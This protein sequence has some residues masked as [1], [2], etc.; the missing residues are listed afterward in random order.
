MLKKKQRDAIQLLV[1]TEMKDSEIKEKLNIS[2]ATFWRWKKN[3][4]LCAELE[5]E[6]RRKFKSLQTKALHTMA[7]L[8][9]EL[10]NFMDFDA[11]D[12]D[13]LDE[14]MTRT[15]I[16]LKVVDVFDKEYKQ[17][18][19]P[20]NVLHIISFDTKVEAYTYALEH[21]ISKDFILNRYGHLL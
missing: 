5:E 20:M 8:I 6:N 4:E 1:Y 16:I 15:F 7:K 21:G 17:A 13:D 2:D 18:Y 9:E 14:A 19:Y 12:Y 11:I 3:E 10:I